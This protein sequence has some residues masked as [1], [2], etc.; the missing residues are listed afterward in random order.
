ML[1]KYLTPFA[2]AQLPCSTRAGHLEMC[3]VVRA[4]YAFSADGILTLLEGLDQGF[5]TGEV[6]EDPE[7][8][9]SEL[10]YPGDFA[11]VKANAE[12]VV[13]AT[14]HVPGGEAAPTCPVHVAVG[15]W[16]KSLLVT[17][18]RARGA[19]APAPFTSLPLRWAEA[20]GGAGVAENPVGKGATGDEWPR[21]LA[22]GDLLDEAS[23]SRRPAGLGPLNV[24]FASPPRATA[25]VRGPPC[26]KRLEIKLG[27]PNVVVC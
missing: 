12:V 20:Y 14:C 23:T 17:G 19:K 10:P 5:L 26:A 25:G 18:P 6:P 24:H 22:P 9:A 8:P 3:V 16:S 21:V 2:S 13:R 15:A 4:T 11:D 7:D 27:A 1:V